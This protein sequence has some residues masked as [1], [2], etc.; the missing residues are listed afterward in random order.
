MVTLVDTHCHLDP[1]YFPNGPED[2][3]ARAHANGVLGF[4]VVGVGRDLSPARAAVDLARK[5]PDRVGAAVGIH[6]HDAVT[7]SDD[8]HAELSSLARDAN[9]VAVG[10]IGLD[11]HYDHSPRDVQR[12]VFARLVALALEVKKPIVVHTR[13]APKDTLDILEAERGRDVGGVIHCFSEDRAFAERALDLG[14]D[15]SF[16]GIVTFKGATSVHEVARWAPADR[17]L[18][19]TD[20]PYLAPVPL[21][22]KSNEPAYVVH[23]AKRVAELRNVPIEEVARLTTANAERRFRKTFSGT[24]T[25]NG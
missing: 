4:V 15:I 2:A 21:R 1:Q 17:I 11:Y 22:G 19:E 12:A 5:I 9:V 16:S 20:S 10:E 25:S 14:F 3:L 8:A 18:V 24:K 7:W 13:E 23:T 6:P